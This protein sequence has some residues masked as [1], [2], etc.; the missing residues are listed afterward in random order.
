MIEGYRHHSP[1]S[2]NLFA[3]S[4]AMW[5]L[6]KVLGLKQPVG[7][8]AHRG[9]AVEDGVTVGLINPDA[10]FEACA[11]VA[12]TRYDTLTAM[13]IDDRRGEVPY[14]HSRHGR[15]GT[16]GT[17]PLRRSVEYARLR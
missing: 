16:Q 8:P 11:N 12:L 3:A 1:S 13:S 15:A 14:H 5:V 7:V 2:L 17:A 10:S 6:E 9:T 4:N